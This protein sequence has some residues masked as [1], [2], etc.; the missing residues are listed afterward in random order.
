MLLSQKCRYALRGLY[1]LALNE[2]GQVLRISE[3]AERQG[4]PPRFLENIFNDLKHGGYVS[5]RR[6]QAGGY[7]LSRPAAE[8]TVGEVIRFIDGPVLLLDCRLPA[9]A[10]AKA[11]P[12]GL[13]DCVLQPIMQKAKD[14]INEIWDRTTLQE[15]A[16]SQTPC[17]K[18]LKP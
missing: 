3:I 9:P 2:D 18:C 7:R 5:A 1:E 4:I 17:R 11:P 16:R 13:A 8:I 14:A 6:G 12:E 15:L 10:R